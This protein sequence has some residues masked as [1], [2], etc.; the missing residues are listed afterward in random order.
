MPRIRK[1]ERIDFMGV[2]RLYKTSDIPSDLRKLMLAANRMHSAISTYRR[3]KVRVVALAEGRSLKGMRAATD[4]IGTI[5]LSEHFVRKSLLPLLDQDGGKSAAIMLLLL[6]VA[7]ETV[8][9]S[10]H[11]LAHGPEFYEAFHDTLLVPGRGEKIVSVFSVGM[12]ELS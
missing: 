12:S 6:V 3:T 11:E 8:H 7:H 1:E 5:V 4:R 10:D 9:D 2:C